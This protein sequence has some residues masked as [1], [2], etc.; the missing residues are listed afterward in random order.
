MQVGIVGWDLIS[1]YKHMAGSDRVF[2][3][4]L[5]LILVFSLVRSL[6]LAW[7][8]WLFSP[9]GRVS[10]DQ[11]KPDASDLLAAIA[12]ANKLPNNDKAT[13]EP[14][15]VVESARPRFEYLWEQSVTRVAAMRDFAVLT[16]I[17]SGLVLSYDVMRY[18]T[19]IQIE[20]PL[21]DADVAGGPAEMLVPLVLGFAVSAVLYVLSSFHSGALARRRAVWNLFVAKVSSQH[22]A[23]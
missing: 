14:W 22:K 21:G 19:A 6:R 5:M 13:E 18:L 23:D 8:L 1:L 16:L 3:L 17:F 4:Y 9:A 11:R 12:L 10:S 7:K 2:I 20:R 15:Q